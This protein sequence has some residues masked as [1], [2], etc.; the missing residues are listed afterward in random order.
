MLGLKRTTQDSQNPQS[1]FIK[2]NLVRDEITLN[3][4]RAKYTYENF[5][6]GII[7]KITL[8]SFYQ[9]DKGINSAA[10]VR[11]AI[12][13]LKQKGNLR[14]LVLDLRDNGGGFLNQ[15]VEVA[16]LFIS[17]GI[18]VISKY[19]DGNEHIYRD[20]DNALFYKGPLVILT[21]KATASAAEI[22][23]Q[24][25][26]DYGVAL[27]VGDERTYGK[28]T[29][30]SQTVTDDSAT[31]FFKVTVGEY[32]T[33]S[34]QTPQ[35]KGVKADI[36]VPGRLSEEHIGERYLENAVPG[37]TIP[38]QYKDDLKDI[39]PSL[40]SWYLR[41]Y[42][43]TMQPKIEKW[44]TMLPTLQKNSQY[45]IEHNK[46][47]QTFIHHLKGIPEENSEDNADLDN[48][49]AALSKKDFGVEDLQ[50]AE[51]INIIKDMIMLNSHD[52][53]SSVA[54]DAVK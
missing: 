20:M 19:S 8:K 14:G 26:Q 53:S 36:V 45:R 24:A 15:A 37:G 44:R 4:D 48:E 10:D 39:D 52:G 42:Y 27:V 32:F 31:S 54:S 7:G 12:K 40:K 29:I 9:G 28:G 46:N 13:E 47:Y 43:A 2:V 50:M 25:L 51:T 38:P 11:N 18:V 23:A 35:I 41:Y 5:G 30:Q 1:N 21:S 16:S 49:T 22:V 17:N 3:E 6:N 33:V 34:G